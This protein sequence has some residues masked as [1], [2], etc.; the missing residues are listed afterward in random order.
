MLKPVPLR[1]ARRSST[2]SGC[3]IP[4]RQPAIGTSSAFREVLRE[5]REQVVLGFYPASSKN[6]GKWHDIQVRLPHRSGY[7][8]RTR[9]GYYDY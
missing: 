5:L 7:S 6:D 2:G 4:P 8:L 3:A 1:A 9:A